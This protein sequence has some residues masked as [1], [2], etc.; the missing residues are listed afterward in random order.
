MLVLAQYQE[1]GIN[2]FLTIFHRMS[3]FTSYRRTSLNRLQKVIR[4]ESLHLIESKFCLI[5]SFTYSIYSCEKSI[6]GKKIRFFHRKIS[7]SYATQEYDNVIAPYYSISFLFIDGQ[8]VAYGRLKTKKIQ[9]V[10]SKS[11]RSNER[12]SLPRGFKYSDLF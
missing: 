6:S 8:V 12:L 1:Y 2:R 11:G 5:F 3:S 9:T 4:Q 10:S 7:V